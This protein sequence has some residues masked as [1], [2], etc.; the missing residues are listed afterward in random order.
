MAAKGKLTVWTAEEIEALNI[1]MREHKDQ[2]A[3][4]LGG[5]RVLYPNSLRTDEAIVRRIYNIDTDLANKMSSVLRARVMNAVSR[6]GRRLA[7]AKTKE[8]PSNGVTP[9]LEARCRYVLAGIAIGVTTR[10]EALERVAEI[11]DV[12]LE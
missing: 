10:E 9:S 7:K 1:A 11:L 8:T 6:P 5:Y 12:K 3:A 4:I 2:P